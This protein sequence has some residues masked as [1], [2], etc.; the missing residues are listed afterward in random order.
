MKDVLVLCYHGVSERWQADI[1]I[2]PDRFEEQ[3]QLLVSRGYR[4]ATFY[5]AVTA[6]PSRRTLAV[7]FDDA[8]QSV[9]DL[10]FPIMERWE[11]PGTVFVPTRMIGGDEP[12]SWQGLDR[13][14]GTAHEDELRGMSWEDVGALADA[15]WEIGSHTQSH[16]YLT[17]IGDDALDR[18]LRDSRTDCEERLGRPC[19]SI[20]YP[21]G[22][23]DDRVTEAVGRAGYLAAASVDPP[24]P[25]RPQPLKWPRLGVWYT[26]DMPRFRRDVSRPMRWLRGSPIWPVLRRATRRS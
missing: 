6:P 5:E 3:L 17:K 25:Y 21:Y 13:W 12:M 1:S 16:P 15:G 11:L 26:H 20:A 9:L 24:I 8:F 22:Y 18:E 14:I 4:G 7:T 23:V 19:R 10:A 2:P